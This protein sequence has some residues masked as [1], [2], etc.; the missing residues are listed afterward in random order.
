MRGGLLLGLALMLAGCTHAPPPGPKI[1]PALAG[2]I[3]ADT[4]VLAGVRLEAIERTPLYQSAFAHR[5]FPFIEQ[6][7]ERV[8]IDP[9]K[10]LW[11][12]LYVSNGQRAA[13]LGH[14]MF[15]D[16]G[17]P[18]L[19]Q[20]GDSRFGYKGF[21]LVG[22]DLNA[23]LLINQTVLAIGDTDELKAMVDAHEKSAG[24][25]AAMGAL[26]ARM[27]AN[28]KMWTAFSNSAIKLPLDSGSTLNNVDKILGM[29]ESETSY[30]DFSRGLTGTAVATARSD[31]DAEQLES[32]F[33]AML[34][35]AR[36]A[37]PKNQPDL[38][39][40]WDGVRVT[41]E[42]REIRV[43]IDEPEDLA[44][45]LVELMMGKAGTAK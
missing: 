18:K 17:E 23:I 16:E 27:P 25:P 6:F 42:N 9:R 12:L 14:G 13:L 40:V 30:L 22:S 32:G 15:S 44:G 38:Q 5:D 21:T 20:R 36:M 28:A 45:R 1:D 19:Q 29:I 34:S 31:Q 10:N 8:S 43:Q 39:K 7:S 24:P 37:I 41:R 3:P 11:E 35:L 26:L 33:T 2:L 4:T